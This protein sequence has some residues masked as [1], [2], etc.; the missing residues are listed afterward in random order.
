[1]STDKSSP[2][3][4]KKS[5]LKSS[6]IV[7]TG[8]LFSRFLG[9]IRDVILAN[10]LGTSIIAEAFLVAQRIPNLLR[11]LIGEGAA[12]A[13]IVP[14]LIDYQKTKTKEQWHKFVNVLLAWALIVVSILTVIGM[15]VSPL[16]VGIIAP[17]FTSDPVKF[18]LTVDLTRM[19]FPYLI[20]IALSALQMGVL[21]TLNSFGAPAFSSCLLNIAMIASMWV[22]SLF[23]W[24][25]AYILAIGVVIGG[26]LQLLWQGQALSQKGFVW[27]WPRKFRHEG[28][29]KV[30]KL[31]VPR[32]W[33][34]AVY[35][36]NMFV[37]TLCASLTFIV[38]GGGIAALYFANRL[39]QFPLGVFAYALNTATLPSLSSSA[40]DADYDT[41]KQTLMFSL[42]NLLFILLPCAVYLLVLSPL[43]VSVIFQHGAFDAHSA[44]I[45]CV[46]LSCMSLG[47]PFFG[48]SRIL[49][50]GFYALQDTKTPVRIAT[51]CLIINAILNV[52]LM[53][54]LKIGGI[55]LASSIAGLANF[56]LLFIEMKDRIGAPKVLKK[57]FLR[58]LPSL[59]LMAFVMVVFSMFVPIPN[60]LIKLL[61]VSLLGWSAFLY[62]CHF[63]GVPEF[64]PL[65][66]AVKRKLGTFLKRS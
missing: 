50:S 3:H 33:G 43:I 63:T 36:M 8:V 42:K 20:L 65:L 41:F 9:F 61:L 38:G 16:I 4:S 1:M 23:S 17:G 29:R 40:S 37:D 25:A 12:N 5:L 62:C 6:S 47:L 27:Q 55:A 49:V 46:A 22:S 52:I 39:I 21:Y 31:L 48:T 30:A 45:T 54:P 14:V 66:G 15:L 60:G 18:H 11:D 7:S 28:M 51:I 53:F 64:K 13:A 59:F 57:F 58:L 32:L 2:L 24:G 34:S 19:M 56:T 35:Q 26:I 10:L 44:Y